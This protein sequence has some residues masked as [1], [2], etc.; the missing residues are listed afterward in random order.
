L[1]RRARERDHAVDVSAAVGETLV[2]RLALESAELELS[3]LME[4]KACSS[5]NPE[6]LSSG[7]HIVA[8]GLMAQRP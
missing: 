8:D 3:L 4:G 2:G 6:I 5:T 1:G 7:G